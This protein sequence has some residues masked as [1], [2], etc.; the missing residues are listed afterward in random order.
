ML[1][2]RSPGSTR[3]LTLSKSPSSVSGINVGCLRTNVTSESSKRPPTLMK[4]SVSVKVD[5]DLICC[6]F[7]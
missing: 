2:E 6:I 1:T 4:P 5:F 3:M 7:R